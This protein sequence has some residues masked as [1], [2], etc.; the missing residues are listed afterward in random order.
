MK[1]HCMKTARCLVLGVCPC[2]SISG[3]CESSSSDAAV[4]RSST[5]PVCSEGPVEGDP[6]PVT[7]GEL[8]PLFLGDRLHTLNALKER[9]PPE[10][11]SL[12]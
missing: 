4:T 11:C 5:S 7:L 2:D 8:R 1:H 3:L 12:A 10:S 9:G 6:A